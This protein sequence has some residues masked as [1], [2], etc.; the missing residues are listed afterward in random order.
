MDGF[1]D[2]LAHILHKTQT[3]KIVT[4]N[5]SPVIFCEEDE[6]SYDWWFWY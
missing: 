4:Q 6:D 5:P 3:K 1:L 2:F